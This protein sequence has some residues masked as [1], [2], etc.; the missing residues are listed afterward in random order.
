MNENIFY[1]YQ[2]RL[3]TESLPFYVGK[4]KDRRAWDHFATRSLEKNTHKNNTIKKALR[5]GVDVVVEM[6]FTELLNSESLAYEV[7][8][9]KRQLSRYHNDNCKSLVK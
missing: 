5:D 3:A 7:W 9:I 8:A 1:V 4:G 6:I 2:L